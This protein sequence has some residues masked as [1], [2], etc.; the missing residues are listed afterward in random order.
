MR[1][2]GVRHRAALCAAKNL[3]LSA[4]RKKVKLRLDL[5]RLRRGRDGNDPSSSSRSA[6]LSK[7]LYMECLRLTSVRRIGRGLIQ[8]RLNK[9]IGKSAIYSVICRFVMW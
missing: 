2:T 8:Y 7:E 9:S 4:K 3:V 1:T 5:R 6:L